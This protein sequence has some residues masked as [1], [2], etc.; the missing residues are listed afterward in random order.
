MH[1]YLLC[2]N[3]GEIFVSALNFTRYGS[4]L[5]L[6]YSLYDLVKLCDLMLKLHERK[7]IKRISND[8][9]FV[10]VNVETHTEGW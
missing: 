8:Y 1:N 5:N 6:N 4:L 3:E 10:V 9:I 2:K 7:C